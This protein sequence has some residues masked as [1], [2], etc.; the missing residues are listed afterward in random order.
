MRRLAWAATV[1]VA[2]GVGWYARG[3]V[4]GGPAATARPAV[5]GEAIGATGAT[6]TT[7]ALGAEQDE[8][9]TDAARLREQAPVGGRAPGSVEAREQ[10][11]GGERADV[12]GVE[13][14]QERV[15]AERP[16]GEEYRTARRDAAPPAAPPAAAE[17]RPMAQAVAP[18]E[19]ELQMQKAALE[20]WTAVTPAAA[21]AVLGAPPVV[22]DGL[23]VTSIELSATGRAVRVRQ[24]L[25]GGTML[26]LIQSRAT[27]EVATGLA[28]G[29]VADAAPRARLAR[30]AEAVDSIMVMGIRVIMRAAVS[31]DSMRLL[32]ERLGRER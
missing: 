23:P 15:T 7:G 20:P 29:A 24:D 30:G 31:A 5:S 26:E 6:G 4:I 12:A 17:P 3:L 18:A 22:L 32:L 10:A 8:A 14:R 25:G 13:G 11:A 9:L 16:A 2:G 21:E 19:N 28:A 1:V 27:D